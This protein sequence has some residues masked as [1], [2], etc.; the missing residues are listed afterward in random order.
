MGGPCGPSSVESVGETPGINFLDKTGRFYILADLTRVTDLGAYRSFKKVFAKMIIDLRTILESP[1][2]FDL[3][4]SP[5]WWHSEGK[6][7]PVLGLEGPLKVHGSIYRAGGKY[8]L[9][10]HLSGRLLVRCDRCLEP[11]RQDLD[12]DFR[13]F[14]ALPSPETPHSEIELC[15]EDLSVDLITAEE[16]QLEEVVREQ[17]YLLLPI[18]SVCREDCSGLCRTCGTNLNE[19]RCR[20]EREGHPAFSKLKA[21]K[22]KGE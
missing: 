11:F 10:G 12:S 16:I 15:E 8:V 5:S 20:C 14:L 7:D 17:I 22:L 13:L 2:G 9:D 3:A 18:K 6:L 4:L 21:L 19:A 1:R